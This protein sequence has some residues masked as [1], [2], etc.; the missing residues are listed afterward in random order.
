MQSTMILSGIIMWGK[1][2]CYEYE[3]F[4][5]PM[6]GLWKVITRVVW[7]FCMVYQVYIDHFETWQFWFV[8]IHMKL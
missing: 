3:G 1:K 5:N 2:K 7:H 4:W 6:L 8:E